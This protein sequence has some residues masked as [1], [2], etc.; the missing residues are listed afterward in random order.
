MKPVSVPAGPRTLHFNPAVTW[1]SGILSLPCE[2]AA[3]EAVQRC[4][5][6]T[7]GDLSGQREDEVAEHDGRGAW[8]RVQS[9]T[10]IRLK[11]EG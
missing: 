1:Q 2:A 9:S 7:G 4:R 10:E 5:K 3:A 6:P 11:R 8:V